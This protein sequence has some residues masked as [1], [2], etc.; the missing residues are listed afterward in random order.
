MFVVLSGSV[1]IVRHSGSGEELFATYSPGMFSG[2]VGLLAGRAVVASGRTR[3]D[4]EILVVDEVALHRVMVTQAELSELIMRAF[5]LRRVAL[6]EDDTGGTTVI[7]SR[8]TNDTHRLRQFLTRNGQPHVY[9]D[10]ERDADTA[11]WLTRLAVTADEL[12]IVITTH[13]QVLRRP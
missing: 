9:L 7:G 2:E 11:A 13:D 4:S 10:L 3:E 8:L 5:I 12:P 6:L 1:D